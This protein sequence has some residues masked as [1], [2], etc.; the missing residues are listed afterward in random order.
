MFS[1]VTHVAIDTSTIE[2][3]TAVERYRQEVLPSLREQAGYLGL[4]ILATPVGEAIAISFWE[5]EE[6]A[7]AGTEGEGLYSDVIRH[8]RSLFRSMPEPESARV[9][10]A[11]GPAVVPH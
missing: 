11:D 9:V 4:L 2:V 8:Y 5:T 10:L 7:T 3:E 6:E 1:R